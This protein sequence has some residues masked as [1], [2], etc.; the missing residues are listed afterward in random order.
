MSL[1]DPG[2]GTFNFYTGEHMLLREEPAHVKSALRKIGIDLNDFD[3]TITGIYARPR[4]IGFDFHCSEPDALLGLATM[5]SE[6]R[7]DDRS[8]VSGKFVAL[9]A[10]GDS[11]RQIGKGSA[12]HMIIALNGKC[13]VHID[14]TGFVDDCGY[15]FNNMLGHGYFDLATDLLPGA[16]VTFGDSGIAGLVAAPM[17]GVDGETRMIFGIKGRW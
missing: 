1:K 13:N 17:K 14:S 8:T 12:I 10:K 11:F 15:N 5:N 3:I 16:F 2:D 7:Q 4:P 9:M 6:L